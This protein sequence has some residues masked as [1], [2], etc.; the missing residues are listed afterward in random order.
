[1]AAAVLH[2]YR[3]A[4]GGPIQHDLFVYDGAGNGCANSQLIVPGGDVP[5]IADEHD[6]FLISFELLRIQRSDT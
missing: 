4:I 1:M 2:A 5:A 6:E 3:G